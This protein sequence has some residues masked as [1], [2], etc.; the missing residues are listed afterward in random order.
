MKYNKITSILNKNITV[1]AQ[2][3]ADFQILF[4]ILSTEQM[5]TTLTCLL[6]GPFFTIWLSDTTMT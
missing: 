5:L 1:N 4:M 3:N 2:R 6:S